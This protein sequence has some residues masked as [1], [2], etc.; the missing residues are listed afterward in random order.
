MGELLPNLQN[1]KEKQALMKLPKIE[2][3]YKDT[4]LAIRESELNLLLNQQPKKEWIKKHPIIK[5]EIINSDGR[6]ETVP[7][8]YIPIERLQWLMKRIFGG[9]TREIKESKLI[10]NSIVVTVRIHYRNIITG[11]MEYQ[12][13][14]GAVPLQTNKDAG[15]TDFNAIKSGAV[16]MGAPAAATFAEK[17]AIGSI[18]RLFG[19]DVNRNE[20]SIYMSQK[21]SFDRVEM[22]KL[23]A[24]LSKLI[25]NSKNT[26]LNDR[27]IDE[28]TSAEA[29][30][31]LTIEKYQEWIQL[32]K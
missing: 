19:A 22:N 10:A 29:E 12:D 30:G 24:E 28:V 16:Q 15:A 26:E 20:E 9:Y 23:S 21:E 25:N 6:K 4:D 32:F 2:E 18:G 14:I 8:E 5:K 7:Y 27:V 1:I 13:G 3:L 31:T 11:E 17:D